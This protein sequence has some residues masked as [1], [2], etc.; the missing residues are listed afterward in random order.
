MNSVCCQNYGHVTLYLR[1]NINYH[2]VILGET[3]G[4]IYF[5]KNLNTSQIK[6]P[7]TNISVPNFS[8]GVGPGNGSKNKADNISVKRLSESRKLN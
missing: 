6:H 5:L 1:Y 2:G 4:K 8:L 3:Q 7:S